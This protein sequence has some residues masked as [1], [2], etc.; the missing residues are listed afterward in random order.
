[1]ESRHW[2]PFAW[3]LRRRYRFVLPD[4]RGFGDAHEVP[5]DHACALTR[6]ADDLHDLFTTHDLGPVALGGISMGAFV[7][8]TYHERYGFADRVE[9]YAHI[10]QSPRILNRED[11]SHGIFGDDQTRLLGE[12]EAV[13][14]EA[15]A[16]GRDTP[17]DALPRAFRR[18]IWR[19]FG[20]F[21][22]AAMGSPVK[23]ALATCGMSIEGIGT[24]ILPTRQ[25][26]AYVDVLASYLEQDYDVRDALDT[27]DVPVT[28]MIGM[29]SRMYPPEG[30]M[31]VARRAPRSRVVRFHRSGHSL[32]LDQPARFTRELRRFLDARG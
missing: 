29:K 31:E 19:A 14:N 9:R 4:M 2:L 23:R 5:I 22:G 1:M 13:L 8:L 6:Y 16:I 32:I 30:Q 27:L 3:A 20:Q 28:V 10:D 7:S 25:W 12:L 24:R 17:Y 26:Y 15:R 18:R 11:W 21:T